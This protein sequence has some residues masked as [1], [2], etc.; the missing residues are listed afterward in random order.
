MVLETNQ[1]LQQV[2]QWGALPLLVIGLIMTLKSYKKLSDK[3]ED[4][5]QEHKQDLRTHTEEMK[6]IHQN[7]INSLNQ[8]INKK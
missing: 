2:Y 7:T 8:L 6:S 4:V 3:L 1:L 5:N